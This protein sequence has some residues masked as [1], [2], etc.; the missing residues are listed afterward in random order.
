MHLIS[1]LKA[2]EGILDLKGSYF[3]WLA[4]CSAKITENDHEQENKNL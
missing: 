3:V 2:S 1:F 4:K